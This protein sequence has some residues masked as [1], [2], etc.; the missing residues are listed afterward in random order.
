MDY[1]K[2]YHLLFNAMTDALQ[3]MEAQNFGASKE[4]LTTA[5]QRAEEMYLD[6]E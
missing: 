1:Q 4:L 6:G 3:Q 5:Q 2:L